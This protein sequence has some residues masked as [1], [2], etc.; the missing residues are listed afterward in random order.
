MALIASTS[1][2]S[3]PNGCWTRPFALALS[4]D[5]GG[6]R[7]V[8]SPE[9]GRRRLSAA[10]PARGVPLAL[11]SRFRAAVVG[12]IGIRQRTPP[13]NR[14]TPNAISITHQLS[15]SDREAHTR[16]GAAHRLDERRR[17]LRSDPR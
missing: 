11:R 16:P 8:S 12:R 6:L 5:G 2:P 14:R 4:R 10:T 3:Y 15:N 17:A 9:F 13:P 1:S 7:F